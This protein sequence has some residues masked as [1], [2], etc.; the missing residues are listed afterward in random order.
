M[1]S[2]SVRRAAVD[3]L[4]IACGS[5]AAI[6]FRAAVRPHDPL[7]LDNLGLTLA[8]GVPLAVLAALVAFA[9][10]GRYRSIPPRYYL[11]LVAGDLAVAAAIVSFVAFAR[12]G[13]DAP[14]LT[15]LAGYVFCATTVTMS[16]RITGTGNRPTRP[17]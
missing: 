2:P 7:S 17:S 12:L 16:Q 10:A 5:T 11:R 4:A 9:A 6:V 8:V 3:A 1:T 15:V 13:V 14:L